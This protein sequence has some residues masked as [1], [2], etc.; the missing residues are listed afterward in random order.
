M[1]NYLTFQLYAP[2]SSWGEPAVG[3]IRNSSR[4]P[5][6]SAVLGLVAAAMGFRRQH[7]E[8]HLTLQ[9]SV[10]FGVKLIGEG[11]PTADYHTTQSAEKQMPH[12]RKRKDEMHALSKTWL[13]SRQYRQDA[14]SVVALWNTHDAEINLSCIKTSLQQ[15]TF[16]L[17]L[18][19]KSCPLALPLNPILREHNA[20]KDALD[21]Y[22]SYCA[23][24]Y[25][26]NEQ[27]NGYFWEATEHAGQN[28]QYSVMRSDSILSRE[29][30]QHTQRKEFAA[31]VSA[32]GGDTDRVS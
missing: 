9:R 3:E 28:A 15:P 25:P 24:K 13:S 18:G 26:P 20:L 2:L 7:D 17:F 31:F 27:V 22:P 8:P 11:L 32:A 21:D 29:R 6:K 1:P 10:G 5:S 16:H 30:W 19:R 4:H 14:L 12:M 23:T